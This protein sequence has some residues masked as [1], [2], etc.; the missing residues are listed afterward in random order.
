MKTIFWNVDTQ[1]D[2]MRDDVSFKGAL[3][4]PDA[5]TIETNLEHLTSLARGLHVPIINTADWHTATSKELSATPDYKTTFPPHCL[6]DTPGA[7]YVPATT[8]L[9]PYVIDWRASAFDTEKVRTH[10]EIVLYKDAFDIFAGSPHADAV[11]RTLQPQR[12]VVY[13]VATNVCV[14][15]AVRGLLARGVDVIVPTDAIKELPELPLEETL[16]T[17]TEK[18]AHLTTTDG[19]YN[20]LRGGI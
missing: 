19:V 7:R 16:H 8:P 12:V 10:R 20:L 14:D 9:D 13:G 1:Y 11:L 6:I 4:V 5:H 15:Y 18:G 3:A 2:F 17:W